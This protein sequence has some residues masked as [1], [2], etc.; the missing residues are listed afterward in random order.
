MRFTGAVLGLVLLSPLS[1]I[2][3]EWSAAPL[4]GLD[5][6]FGGDTLI[7]IQYEDG[8]DQD[9][10][11]GNGLVFNGGVLVETPVTGL[12]LRAVVGWKYSTSMASNIDVTKTAFPVELTARY[13][14]GSGFFVGGGLTHHL[15]PKLTVDDDSVDFDSST[16]LVL[17]AGW[18]FIV[19]GYSSL[20]YD[21]E[22]ET[23]DASSFNI[24]LEVPLNF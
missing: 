17:R 2:A 11:A 19:V 6:Q 20:D 13:G 7:T 5:A 15:N 3:E 4:L 9:I 22:S 16:G 1:V 21:Y 12:D 14:V 24:G 18:E 23:Y 10:N 8:S